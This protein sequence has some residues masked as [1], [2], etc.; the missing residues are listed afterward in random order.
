MIVVYDA[1][2]PPIFAAM[3]DEP[4]A[5]FAFAWRIASLDSARDERFSLETVDGSARPES[6]EEQDPLPHG[7]SVLRFVL[8][9]DA[10]STRADGLAGWKWS[11][12]A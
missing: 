2:P 6:R 11:R 3:Y 7:L 8:G 4:A 10:T 9:R 1:S 12:H 5:D